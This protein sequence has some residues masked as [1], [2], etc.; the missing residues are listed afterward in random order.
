[1]SGNHHQFRSALTEAACWVVWQIAYLV[2]TPFRDWRCA[3]GRHSVARR[4]APDQLEP[5]ALRLA[6][7]RPA[8]LVLS[9]AVLIVLY[10]AVA[11]W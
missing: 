10:A 8:D 1:M 7:I 11:A 5:H 6:D 9:A 2:V 3:H 4:R